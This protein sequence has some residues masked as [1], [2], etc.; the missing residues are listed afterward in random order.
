MDFLPLK[1]LAAW[2]DSR[3]HRFS[4]GVSDAEQTL[5]NMVSA[6]T[7]IHN[8]N[9]I[10][11]DIKP[12][13]ILYERDRGAIL[14]DFGLAARIQERRACPGGTPWYVPPEYLSQNLRGPESDVFALGIVML[15][16]L[17]T[18]PL[19]DL[20]EPGWAIA[21][22]ARNPQASKL[23]RTWLEKAARARE[24]LG[25][26]RVEA[27]VKGMTDFDLDQRIGLERVMI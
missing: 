10:H 23:M 15:Y 17:K 26:G 24:Q 7:Y 27:Y 18:I 8:Q 20:T 13:N 1:D 4:G 22:V 16:L 6:M 21:D 2:G 19:P 11:N 14:I 9:I 5:R 12:S 25:T 3:T